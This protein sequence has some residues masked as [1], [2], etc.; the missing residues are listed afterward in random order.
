MVSYFCRS[1]SHQSTLEN[2]PLA[3]KSF[4]VCISAAVQ[5]S[6]MGQCYRH[7]EELRC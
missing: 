6:A 7:D 3:M 4:D 1:A 2:D 5:I